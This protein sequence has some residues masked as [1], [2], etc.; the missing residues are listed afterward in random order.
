MSSACNGALAIINQDDDANSIN[1][2]NEGL[3]KIYDHYISTKSQYYKEE[4]RWPDAVFWKNRK[5]G[6]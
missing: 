1:N 6:I 3:K 2:Y 4:K 5:V